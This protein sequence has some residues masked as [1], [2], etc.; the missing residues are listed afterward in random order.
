[1]FEIM[2]SQSRANIM[3]TAL[4]LFAH[5]GYHNTS[6][7]QIAKAAGISKGL[8]YNYFESKE[9]LLKRIVFESMAV[10]D[11]IMES[12]LTEQQ[13]PKKQLRHIIE[14]TFAWVRSNRDY[15]KLLTALSFQ[16]ESIEGIADLARTKADTMIAQTEDLLSR[17][18]YDNVKMEALALG[19]LLDGVMLQYLHLGDQYPFEAM[20]DHLI[21]K[22]CS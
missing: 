5:Q 20:K 11:E 13:D 2:R 1:Q 21:E 15:W 7:A 10:G 6:I 18:G 16:I 9:E 22:Y 17:M 19:G 12:G 14:S 4:E 3:Q 8:L